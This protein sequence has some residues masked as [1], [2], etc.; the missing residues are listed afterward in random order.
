MEIERLDLSKIQRYLVVNTYLIYYWLHDSLLIIEYITSEIDKKSFYEKIRNVKVDGNAIKN[1]NTAC[2]AGLDSSIR[3]FKDKYHKSPLFITIALSTKFFNE[4][5]SKKLEPEISDDELD[6]WIDI[7]KKMKLIR[8]L[9]RIRK[10]GAFI[11]ATIILNILNIQELFLSLATLRFIH[12]EPFVVRTMLHLINDCKL[13]MRISLLAALTLSNYNS[14]HSI[15]EIEGGGWYRRKTA[16]HSV[17]EELFDVYALKKFFT[18]VDKKLGKNS[19]MSSKFNLFESI[20]NTKLQLNTKM[21][22]VPFKKLW[23]SK[24]TEYLYGDSDT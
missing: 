4:M 22:C 20:R 1:R 11:F 9:Y 24:T 3:E 6:E 17:H 21:K 8:G 19:I 13:D 18:F 14:E 12:E 10:H 23:S 2:F 5:N 7:C 15:M 16:E